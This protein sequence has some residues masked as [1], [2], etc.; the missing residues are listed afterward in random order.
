MFI[1]FKAAPSSEEGLLNDSAGVGPRREPARHVVVA[2]SNVMGR[3]P[4]KPVGGTK[5]PSC[6]AIRSLGQRKGKTETSIH[7]NRSRGVFEDNG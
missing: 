3:N 6:V 7:K 1:A 2:K 5:S 4:V